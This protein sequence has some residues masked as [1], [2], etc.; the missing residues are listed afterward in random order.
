MKEHLR[1]VIDA[2]G[3]MDVFQIEW[4][5]RVDSAVVQAFA[6]LKLW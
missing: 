2:V 4:L 6:D 3:G 1:G 5:S